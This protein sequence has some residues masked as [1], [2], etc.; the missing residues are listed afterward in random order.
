MGRVARVVFVHA[1]RNASPR[2]RARS[3]TDA[4]KRAKKEYTIYC[5]LA[6][7]CVVGL[8]SH[9]FEG[10]A[11]RQLFYA[12]GGGPYCVRGARRNF[13]PSHVFLTQFCG[14]F[15]RPAHDP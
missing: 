11:S 6:E 4:R 5:L 1:R 14:S 10:T 3:P 12:W 8:Q 9:L 2:A 7:T 13:L 15:T